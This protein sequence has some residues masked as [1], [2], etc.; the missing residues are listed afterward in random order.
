MPTQNMPFWD[1]DYSELKDFQNQ[2]IQEKL[3]TGFKFLFCK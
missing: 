2:E 1:M 3:R